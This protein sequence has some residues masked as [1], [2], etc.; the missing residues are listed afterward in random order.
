MKHSLFLFYI[1]IFA[2]SCRFISHD[3]LIDNPSKSVLYVKID[4]EVWVLPS[5]SKLHVGLSHGSHNV[6]ICADSNQHVVI[7]STNITIQQD[8]L[9]NAA[10][11]EYIIVRH[12]Y[13][14][15]ERNN[16]EQAVKPIQLNG[17]TYSG[18]I[19]KIDSIELFV[20]MRW[21]R[22]P[23]EPISETERVNPSTLTLIK[24]YRIEEFENEFARNAH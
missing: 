3:V 1:L 14:T 12:N 21:D 18:N 8:G 24:I 13:S 15:K 22:G 20:A 5:K 10:R 2:S 9:L 6:F 7:D 16:K 4:D 17:Y 23:D 11:S 19:E